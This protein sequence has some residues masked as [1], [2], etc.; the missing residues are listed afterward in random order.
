VVHESRTLTF[1]GLFHFVFWEYKK[2]GSDGIVVRD[3]SGPEGPYQ[4]TTTAAPGTYSVTDFGDRVRVQLNFVLSDTAATF[5]VD[6]VAR[7]A[8]RRWADTGELFWQ[9]IGAETDLPSHDVHILVSPPP[10]VTKAQVRAWAHGPLYGT[11]TIRPDAA[12]ALQVSPL[13]ANTFVSARLTFP[14]AAL[15]Q[16]PQRPEARLQTILAQE[17]KAADKANSDRRWARLKVV[18]WGLL[19][20]GAPLAAVILAIFLYVRYGREPRTAFQ[21]QYLRDFPDPRLSPALVGFIWEMGGVDQSAA[22]AT[23]LDLVDRG[24]VGIERLTEHRAGLL[25]GHDETDYEMTLHRDKLE[26]LEPHERG[27]LTFL[28][29]DIAQADSFAMGELRDLAKAN[30]TAWTSG[31]RDWKHLVEQAGERRG[32]LDAAADRMAF[33]AAAAGFIAAVAAAAA[34]I[35]AQYFWFF[36]GLAPAVAVIF[37]ARAVKRRSQEAAELHAQYA[38]IRRY[39]KDFGRMD[40]KPPDSVVLWQHFLVLA[41]VFGMAA[42]VVKHLQVKVPELVNDPAFGTMAFMMVSPGGGQSGFAAMSGGFAAAMSVASSSSSSGAGGGGGFSG[43]GGGG[44]G[45]G[46]GAG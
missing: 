20:V 31:Y 41:V 22:M 8:A 7:G 18:L 40:E 25:G 13:P 42:E 17:K 26:G 34:A 37:V 2:A 19:G 23:L 36:I 6:Y 38:A 28:F 32:F 29:D 15:S 10:G 24:V 30:R 1:S 4:L 21:A 46:F 14:A 44:G 43:G 35:F 3:A 9:F 16:A 33:A 45:G 12:V 39:L 11:V 27:L 5:A